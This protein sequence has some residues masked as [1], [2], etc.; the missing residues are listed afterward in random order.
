LS[1]RVWPGMKTLNKRYIAECPCIYYYHLPYSDEYRYVFYASLVLCNCRYVQLY[2]TRLSCLCYCSNI[3]YMSLV[4]RWVLRHIL[5]VSRVY[6]IADT[7][8]TCL[9]S[10]GDWRDIFYVSIAIVFMWLKR[11]STCL[12]YS[13][14]C[15]DIF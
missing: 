15:R 9:S 2:S 6:V 8:S 5:L 3:F 7:Y 11:H 4:F 13:G 14:D 10:S 12:S 1:V